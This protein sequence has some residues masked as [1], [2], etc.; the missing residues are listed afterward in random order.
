MVVKTDHPIAKILRKPDLARSIV[1]WS[2]ELSE[3]GLKFEPCGSVKGQH[4]SKFVAELPARE[5]D[6]PLSW[7][8][9]V[10]GLVGKSGSGAGIILEGPGDMLVT[11]SLIFRFRVSN[12]QA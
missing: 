7:R 9:Y 1:G 11:Q 5:V 3:F 2:V 10:D 4:L 12:N 8:L 6:P